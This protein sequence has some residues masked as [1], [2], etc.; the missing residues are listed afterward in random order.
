MAASTGIH[1]ASRLN[2]DRGKGG[3]GV[4]GPDFLHLV[5]FL[6]VGKGGGDIAGG[7]G[8]VLVEGVGGEGG[9]DNQVDDVVHGGL[10]VSGGVV[11]NDISFLGVVH[12][13]GAFW[14]LEGSMVLV[15]GLH[16]L[17]VQG[18]VNNTSSASILGQQ[19]KDSVEGAL[20][21]G[22]ACRFVGLGVLGLEGFSA[23]LLAMGGMDT[24]AV[25]VVVAVGTGSRGGVLSWAGRPRRE[26]MRAMNSGSERE[27]VLE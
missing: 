20:D 17:G 15:L 18:A 4:D 8:R 13:E 26:R 16:C 19:T 1:R 21:I 6:V 7:G 2:G 12:S 5:N 11:D 22:V 3:A 23:V 10:A 27:L 9:G 24:S 14:V 25:L